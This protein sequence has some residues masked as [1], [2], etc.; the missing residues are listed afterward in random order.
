[1]LGVCRLVGLFLSMLLKT[2]PGQAS[3]AKIDHTAASLRRARWF[4]CLKPKAAPPYSHPSSGGPPAASQPDLPLPA[5]QGSVR[6]HNPGPQEKP[7]G[8]ADLV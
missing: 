8:S 1:M 5:Q 4:P 3:K 2:P 6:G 7:S